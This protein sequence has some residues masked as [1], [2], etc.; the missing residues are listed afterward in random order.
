MV[1]AA[2]WMLCKFV[3]AAV[4]FSA[5]AAHAQILFTEIMHSPGGND[6]LWEWVEIVNTSGAPLDLDGWVFD[7]DDDGAIGGAS[8]G[9]NISASLENNTIVPASGVAVLYPADELDFMPE[10][11]T[12]AW[13]GEITLIGVDGFTSLS[14]SDAIGLWPS[15]ASYDADAIPDVTVSPRRTFANAIATFNY[16]AAPVPEDGYSI[17]WNGAGSATNSANWLASVENQLGAFASEQTTNENTQINS[18][19]DRGNPGVLPGGAASEGLRITEIM[20]APDSPLAPVGYQEADFEWIE[21]HNNTP[22]EIDFARTPYVF[23][24][25]TG[26][27]LDAGNIRA[28]TIAAGATGIL[29]NNEQI[30]P[31]QMQSMWGSELTYIPVEFWPSLNN[32]GGDTIALWDGFFD[33]NTEASTGTPR[34]YANAVAA[35]TYNAVAS[36]GWPT[37]LSGRS[38]WL[39]NLS[40]DP[41]AGENWTRAGATGDAL[42]FQA[43]AIFE[44]AIDHPGGDVGSPGFV[45]GDVTPTLPGDYNGDG[46][47]D[48]ADYVVWRKND[49][50]P[51]DYNTWRSNFG[52]TAAGESEA[53]AAAVPEP[54]AS[55]LF[56]AGLVAW[57]AF[58]R[59]RA[60]PALR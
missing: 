51:D 28:G 9:A 17:A 5:S 47:V 26:S 8:G 25:T 37:I 1:P 4:L 3:S 12:N 58:N 33:Y 38:I 32:T 30:T 18:T 10:R 44:M 39:N 56:A 57:P 53:R 45:A 14:Q 40:G 21:V 7:D 36:Q 41:N 22:N 16:S 11:F 55:L 20:F 6:A 34:T 35:V 29:F 49:G 24:D 46:A 27:K 54:A 60:S 52:R 42:S 15:R 43:A 13:G 19:A 50:S 31:E 59:R 2:R 23:D 48:G